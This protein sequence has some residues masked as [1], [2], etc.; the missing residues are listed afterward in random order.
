MTTD[1]E[2]RTMSIVGAL[3][4]RKDEAVVARVDGNLLEVQ[5]SSLDLD[6]LEKMELIMEIEDAFG[7]MLDQEDVVECHK[8]SDLVTVIRNSVS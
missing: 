4:K 6:S 1:I 5:F 3:L 2:Q 7:V 8:V